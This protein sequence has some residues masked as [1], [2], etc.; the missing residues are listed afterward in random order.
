MYIYVVVL[1]MMKSLVQGLMVLR[2]A[3]TVWS[4]WN[5]SRLLR[6]NKLL[7]QL[8]SVSSSSSSSHCQ[9]RRFRNGPTAATN[10][11][12]TVK[13]NQ[14]EPNVD[15]DDTTTIWNVVESKPTPPQKRHHPTTETACIPNEESLPSLVQNVSAWLNSWNMT[16]EIFPLP[17]SSLLPPLDDD[18]DDD[19][20]HFQPPPIQLYII[21]FMWTQLSTNKTVTT[22]ATATTTTT[23]QQIPPPSPQESLSSSAT[24][25][26]LL[27][28]IPSP[29]SL[30]TCIPAGVTQYMTDHPHHV[31]SNLFPD[32]K[33]TQSTASTKSITSDDTIIVHPTSNVQM[34][35]LHQDIWDQER[36]K[37]IVQSRLLFRLNAMIPTTTTTTTSVE[38]QPRRL[39]ARQTVVRRID[40][41]TARDFLWHH[42]LWG[43]TTYTKYSYG[44]YDTTATKPC[45]SNINNNNNNDDEDHCDGTTKYEPPL[46]AVATFSSRRHVRRGVGLEQRIY[47]SHELIRTCSCRNM[48]IVGGISK[49]ISAFVKDQN[50]DDIVTVI[51]RDWGIGQSN[52]YTLGFRTVVTMLPIPMVIHGKDGR[53]RHLIGAGIQCEDDPNKDTDQMDTQFIRYGL[54]RMVVAE[55]ETISS[56][57]EAVQCLHRHEYFLTYDAGVERLLLL[58]SKQHDQEY[59]QSLWN[60]SI[61]QYTN[62]HYSSISGIDAIIRH[63][64]TRSY[65]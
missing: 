3:P 62:V 46:V 9:I 31:L 19:T 29:T 26:L 44:L 13:S 55:L 43:S 30:E 58:T 39:Y 38:H 7:V 51:D 54:P 40:F 6:H 47:R 27:H 37:S 20:P 52:W 10:T 45:R 59:V 21:R 41:P 16:Y 48:S 60:S 2:I 42:H 25:F 50:V 33:R 12:D 57:E 15:D 53:R 64:A 11:I 17:I 8:P 1:F 65:S 22:S 56:Y 28:L 49:L 36:T 32:K 18:D 61:P 5:S 23:N 4:V 24:A 63:V 34:I 14:K 35:H